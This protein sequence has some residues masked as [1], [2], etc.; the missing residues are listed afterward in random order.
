ML[1]SVVAW[2]TNRLFH[3]RWANPNKLLDPKLQINNFNLTPWDS[4]V[5]VVPTKLN[6]ATL[7][8]LIKWY[9]WTKINIF[10]FVVVVA[11]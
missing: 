3:F 7:K 8:H 2:Q 5:E 11:L 10:F 4:K 1:L 9:C 6:A